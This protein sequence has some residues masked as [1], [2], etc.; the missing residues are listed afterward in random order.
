MPHDLRPLGIGEILDAG[1]KL[2]MRHWRTLVLSVVGLVLPVQI[3]SALVTASVAPEQFDFTT[4]QTGVTEDEEAEFLVGQGIVLLLSF[5]SVLLA[6]AVCFKA[7]ADAYLGIEPDWRRSLRFAVRRLLGLVV[8]AIAYGVAI[9]IGFLLVI[10]PGIWLAVA[11][12]VAVPALLLERVGPFAAMGRSFRLVRGRWWATFGALLVG[13]LLVGILGG[14]V[15]GIV[16]VVPGVIADG[17]TV[18]GAI[19]AVVGG[20]LGAV[21]TTPYSAAVIAL[22]YFDLRVRKEGLDLQLIAEGAGVERDPDAPLPAPFVADSRVDRG[23]GGER[24]WSPTPSQPSESSP[25]QSPPPSTNT[26]PPSPWQS[27]TS[28]P[29]PPHAPPWRGAAEGAP[30]GWLP[31]RAADPP[32][33]GAPAAERGSSSAGENDPGPS[34]GDGGDGS[35]DDGGGGSSGGSGGGSSGG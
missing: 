9:V 35:S 13:Y 11:F 2:F 8:L 10:V 31:P 22:V 19:G 1:I 25:W 28:S 27:P 26:P 30:S 18:V 23:P 14:I 17:N 33:D 3:I 32:G 12:S 20:T 34:G 6:T 4:T 5:I 7:V 29:S 24:Y 15:Q 21:L 16:M